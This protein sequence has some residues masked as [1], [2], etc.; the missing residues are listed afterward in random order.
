[1]RKLSASMTESFEKRQARVIE[2][3]RQRPTAM[4]LFPLDCLPSKSIPVTHPNYYPPS[5]NQRRCSWYRMRLGGSSRSSTGDDWPYKK[6]TA[7]IREST[8]SASLF[9]STLG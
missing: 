1:M 3:N 6:R 7:N 2:S 8:N 4:H 5:R 9:P